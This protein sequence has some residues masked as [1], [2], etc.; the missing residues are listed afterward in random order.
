MIVFFLSEL[1]HFLVGPVGAFIVDRC[2]CRWGTIVGSFI[3]MTGYIMSAF[4]QSVPSKFQLRLYGTKLF[5]VL[6]LT[7]GL[8]SG[9]GGGIANI[10]GIVVIARYFK[11]TFH[12]NVQIQ[13]YF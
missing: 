8:I 10:A 5:S 6:C 7:F 1:T 4:A 12:R 13:S 2:G 3:A 11:V 9:A